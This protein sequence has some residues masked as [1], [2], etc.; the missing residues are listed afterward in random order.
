MYRASLVRRLPFAIL[1]LAAALIGLAA[2]Q[3]VIPYSQTDVQSRGLDIILVM[4]LSSS[5]QETMGRRREHTR[6][7]RS[8]AAPGW[9]R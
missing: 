7:R 4:D 8:R 3:P 6:A 2:M 9:T 1:A 5:M